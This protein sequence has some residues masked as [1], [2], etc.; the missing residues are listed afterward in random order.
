MAIREIFRFIEQYQGEIP[1]D[2]LRETLRKKGY[3]EDEIEAA[4]FMSENA[5]PEAKSMAGQERKKITTKP[6]RSTLWGAVVRGQELEEE[7][8][9]GS[10]VDAKGQVDIARRVKLRNRWE[11][12]AGLLIPGAFYLFG[13]TIFVFAELF[14]IVPD[15]TQGASLG[16]S[17]IVSFLLYLWLRNLEAGFG[18]GLIYGI[19]VLSIVLVYTLVFKYSGI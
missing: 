6:Q 8:F 16:M 1:Q 3:P 2:K 17:I 11:L 10:E 14:F 13:L 19:L 5:A 9:Q 7:K 4:F 15:I 12:T 18:R